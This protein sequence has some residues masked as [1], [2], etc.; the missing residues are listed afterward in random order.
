MT[1]RAAIMQAMQCRM[2][3]ELLKRA[4]MMQEMQRKQWD[5]MVSRGVIS[6]DLVRLAPADLTPTPDTPLSCGHPDQPPTD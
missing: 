2:F 4:P 5:E 1:D 6:D 3:E